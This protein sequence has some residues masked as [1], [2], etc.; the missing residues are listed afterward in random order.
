LIVENSY[1]RI[2]RVLKALRKFAVLV[3]L[4]VLPL[5]GVAASL[6]DSLCSSA[7]AQ[8][9]P[10]VGHG[11]DGHASSSHEQNGSTETTYSGNL[12]CH[13]VFTAIPV[14]TADAGSAEPPAFDPQHRY[15]PWLFFPEQP[16]PVPLA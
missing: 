7:P 5:Q 1:F 10:V 2:R 13:H 6:T 16:Q 14:I 4:L 12:C 8:S 9:Q 15:S 3:L 11:D